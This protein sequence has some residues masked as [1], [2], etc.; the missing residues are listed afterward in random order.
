MD[1]VIDVFV[2][3]DIALQVER[4]TVLDSAVMTSLLAKEEVKL[5]K[6]TATKDYLP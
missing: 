6:V 1:G 5:Q 4:G 2:N 3:N